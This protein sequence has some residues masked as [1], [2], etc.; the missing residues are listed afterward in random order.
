MMNSMNANTHAV[1]TNA[2]IEECIR[3]TGKPP[4]PGICIDMHNGENAA[5]EYR[6]RLVANEIHS[7]SR[8][9]VVAATPP[10]EALNIVL[11]M[12]NGRMTR[13]Q[14]GQHTTRHELGIHRYSTSIRSRLGKDQGVRGPA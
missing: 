7:A 5:P 10:L 14:T 11:I 1:N 13:V 2:Y 12:A 9:Y 6:S 8:E 4:I 3:E